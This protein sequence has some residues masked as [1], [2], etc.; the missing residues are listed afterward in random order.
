MGFCSL[1]EDYEGY[2]LEQ[3][4]YTSG[5]CAAPKDVVPFSIMGKDCSQHRAL[6]DFRG[7]MT[8]KEGS[9]QDS[10]TVIVTVYDSKMWL[11]MEQYVTE[12]LSNVQMVLVNQ[13]AKYYAESPRLFR[14]PAGDNWTFE[15]NNDI[16]KLTPEGKQDF[17]GEITF[18]IDYAMNLAD[19]NI[20]FWLWDGPKYP[21]GLNMMRSS[22][23]V[24]DF[25]N[26][27]QKNTNN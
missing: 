20:D 27:K 10:G 4:P 19:L 8:L 7:S 6:G 16:V 3:C 13:D 24:Q 25:I 14:T 23:R 22:W 15:L 9:V 5:H 2:M 11:H 1:V 12:D 21:N 26:L 17:P 18:E